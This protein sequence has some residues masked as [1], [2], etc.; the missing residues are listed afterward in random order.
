MNT[1]QLFNPDRRSKASPAFIVCL[2][3]LMCA[4]LLASLSQKSFGRVFVSNVTYTNFNGIRCADHGNPDFYLVL[5][6]DRKNLPGS[7]TQR[8]AGHLDVCL[9]TGHCADT[10]IE[11]C[12]S[13]N[14]E[15][16][17]RRVEGGKV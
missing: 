6:T 9:I 13:R 17:R 1:Q 12:G 15:G 11:E 14:G 3:V 2:A 8:S 16:G 4:V 5:S 7:N 10:G